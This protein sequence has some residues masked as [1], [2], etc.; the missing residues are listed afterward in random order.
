M[1]TTRSTT[2]TTL[3]RSYTQNLINAR[4]YAGA[5]TFSDHRIVVM[6]YED[7]WTKLYKTANRKRDETNKKIN[8]QQLV[9][10]EESRKMYQERLEQ[11]MDE[12]EIDTWEELSSLV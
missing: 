8:T 9:N 12:R 10:D 7:D 11:E 1:S 2:S 6:E 4:S 5:E 3:M